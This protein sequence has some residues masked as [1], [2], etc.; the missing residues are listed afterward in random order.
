MHPHHRHRSQGLH[1]RRPQNPQGRQRLVDRPSD[2]G[3]R[4][5]SPVFRPHPYTVA[6]IAAEF[7]VTRP[8]I[9]RHLATTPSQDHSQR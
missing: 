5:L 2:C 9:Y 6:Q 3:P 7:G 4:P 1:R 8:T